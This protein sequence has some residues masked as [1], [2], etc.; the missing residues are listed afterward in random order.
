MVINILIIFYNLHIEIKPQ[1]VILG[2][3]I[4]F[5][6]NKQTIALRLFHIIFRNVDIVKSESQWEFW[7]SSTLILFFMPLAFLN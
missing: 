1:T 6:G 3:K 2:A 7:L 5:Y 4:K